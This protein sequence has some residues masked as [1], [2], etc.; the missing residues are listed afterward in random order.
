MLGLR[1]GMLDRGGGKGGSDIGVGWVGREGVVVVVVV[2]E[3]VEGRRIGG[4]T[5]GGRGC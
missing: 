4:W 5:V 3:G 1:M 2:V